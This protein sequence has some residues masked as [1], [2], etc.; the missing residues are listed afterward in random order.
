MSFRVCAILFA[1]IFITACGSST[2]PS[3]TPEPAPAGATTITMVSGAS[4]LSTTAYSPN[5]ITVPVG[6]TV[7]W[8]NSD[9]TT[10]TAVANG[11]AF[12]SPNVAPNSRFNFTFT[13]AG[14]FPYHCTIHPNMVGTITVQ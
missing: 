10:H 1:T 8:L 9:S 12:A 13:T 11:G 14:S 3:G 2:S 5:P 7:S 6:T 4:T